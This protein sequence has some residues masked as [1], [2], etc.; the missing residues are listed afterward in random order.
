MHSCILEIFSKKIV[1]VMPKITIKVDFLVSNKIKSDV[2]PD[3]K[4][5]KIIIE[6]TSKKCRDLL[7]GISIFRIELQ[8]CLKDE[9]EFVNLFSRE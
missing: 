5:G 1:V 8:T 9:T 3:R 2:L 6:S 4:S 7:H